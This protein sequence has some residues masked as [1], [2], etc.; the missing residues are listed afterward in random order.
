MA[1]WISRRLISVLKLRS[2]G[3]TNEKVSVGLYCVVSNCAVELVV[4]RLLS[5]STCHWPPERSINWL[6]MK[7]AVRLRCV[8]EK[9]EPPPANC[10]ATGMV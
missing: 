7:F 9:A 2:S 8:T 4:V 5:N 6:E 3:C 10:E 1:T